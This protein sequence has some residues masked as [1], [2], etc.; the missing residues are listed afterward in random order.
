[1]K[2]L[3]T[4]GNGFIGTSL[5]EGLSSDKNFQ[6]ASLDIAQPREELVG[7]EH[8]FTDVRDHANLRKALQRFPAEAVVHL[9]A[10]A[11]VDPS[12]TDPF[13][14]Y[15][16]NVAGT[17]SVLEA[18]S[19]QNPPPHFILAS[20]EAIYGQADHY[21][22][23][24]NDSFRPASPYAS[25]KIAADVLTQQLNGRLGMQTCVLRSGMGMGPRSNPNEQVVSRFILKALQRK[26]LMFPAGEIVHPTRDI[27]PVQNFVSGVKLVLEAKAR[28][29]YNIASG[30]EL[31]ILEVA[32]KIV[33]AVGMGTIQ[34]S[35]NFKYREGEVGMRT[36]LDITKARR[37]LGYEPHVSFEVALP[38]TIEWLKR[39][40]DTYW[41]RP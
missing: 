21:P 24:E 1:M 39:H 40:A 41:G 29:V 15:S 2:V 9:C 22:T 33:E 7:V 31:S 8:I 25:S 5:L 30:R 23:T 17:L 35:P 38:A 4:G 19:E 34:Y 3:I 16:I 11:R 6:L 20:S 27:N 32:K 14:T 26:P 12:L 28:G 37:E 36:F 18:I 13:T 10:Q